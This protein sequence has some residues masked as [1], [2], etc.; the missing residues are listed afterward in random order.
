MA[1]SEQIGTG[2]GTLFETDRATRVEIIL[3]GFPLQNDVINGEPISAE[4]FIFGDKE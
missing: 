4:I 1:K 3:F 2:T